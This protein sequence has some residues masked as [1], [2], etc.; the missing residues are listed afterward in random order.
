MASMGEIYLGPSGDEVLI[1]M[2]ANEIR[3]EP[4]EG[5][6]SER[7][8]NGGLKTD[9]TWLKYTFKISNNWVYQDT[10]DT[11]YERHAIDDPMNLRIWLSDTVFFK[12]FNGNCPIV[13]L[14]PFSSV[15]F[16]NGTV[17]RYKDVTLTFVEI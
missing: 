9:I 11:L 7:A 8:Y 6:R 1:S 10:L 15:D 14:L 16:P 13:R 2:H 3:R 12:N 17:K 5:G 4:E